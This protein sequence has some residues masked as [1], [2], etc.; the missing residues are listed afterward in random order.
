MGQE[1]KKRRR[2]LLEDSLK[3]FSG[4]VGHA[5]NAGSKVVI[6]LP[7]FSAKRAPDLP[8]GLGPMVEYRDAL[9][10]AFGKDAMCVSFPEADYGDPESV[11]RFQDDGY[12]PNEAG[13]KILAEGLFRAI[14]G[15]DGP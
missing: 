5:K 7:P 4:M 3:Y 9:A 2:V 15:G 12:H 6:V 11:N 8:K 13:A 1:R 10:E 14:E